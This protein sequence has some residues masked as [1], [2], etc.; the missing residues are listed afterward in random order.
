MPAV[1]GLPQRCISPR[2]LVLVQQGDRLVLQAADPSAPVC[3]LARLQAAG[4]YWELDAIAGDD[5]AATRPRVLRLGAGLR[6]DP[7]RRYRLRI[8]DQGLDLDAIARP[9]WA[10][11][12]GRDQDGLFA[13]LPGDTQRRCCWIGC[14]PGEFLMGSPADEPERSSDERRHPVILT[15]GLWLAETACTQALGRA[16]LDDDPSGFKG[17]E[18]P[19]EQVSWDDISQRFLPA[20][21]RLVPGLDARLPSE[22]EWEYACRAGTR[23]PF[24]FG[25]NISTEQVNYDGDYPYGDAP[26]GECRAR[27]I[28]VKALPANPWGLYQMHGNVYEWVADGPGGYPAGMVEDPVGP[29]TPAKRV[30]RGGDWDA[31]ARWVPVCAPLR[32]RA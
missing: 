25:D 24:S 17:P 18:R 6:L 9:A 11:G 23:T 7:G 30:L 20:L 3:A 15:Q 13:E 27:T 31:S 1:L 14:P 5:A 21:N 26:K 16:V 32:P 8:D 28:D 4:D 22:A 12:I 29:A 2:A 19:V 10:A